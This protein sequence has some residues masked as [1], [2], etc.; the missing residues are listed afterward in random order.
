[1]TNRNMV[2]TIGSMAGF[3]GVFNLYED[4]V[5]ISYLPLA[6]VMERSLLM[7][8]MAYKMQYG[9]F[10]GD[11]FK[12]REDLLVLRPTVMASVPRLY[13]RFY[14]VMQ[15]KIGELTGG[16][17][18]LAERAIRTKLANLR[19]SAKT[20]HALYDCILFNK[21]KAILGGRVRCMVT[22]S[23][24]ISQEVVEFLKIAF[25]C[26]I[27]EGYGQ[28]ECSAPATM[29]W[30]QDAKSGHVGGPYKTMMIKLVDVPEMNYT[31]K[32]TDS[33]G[34]PMPRGEIVYKGANC[35]KGYFRDPV[36]T[37]ETIDE[38]GFVHTGDI[39]TFLSN[40]CLKIIDRKKNIFKLS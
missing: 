28:T 20:T 7:A 2:S 21:F 39:G 31:S 15:Q 6:H 32:D 27:H 1:M 18:R 23:A 35:F 17:R 34:Q 14:D 26:Q 25:C 22:G 3:D 36:N 11:V 16:K 4:D 24:P 33:N 19:E 5:Y 30:T 8:S 29:S 13:N 40:G 37:K 38:Q 9:F 10:Q 12:L